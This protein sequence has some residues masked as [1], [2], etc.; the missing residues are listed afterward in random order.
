MSEPDA[1]LVGAVQLILDP[2]DAALKRFRGNEE[3]TQLVSAARV[4]TTNGLTQTNINHKGVH[5]IINVTVYP[6]AASVVPKIQG[7]DPLSSVFYDLLDGV[8]IVA[9]GTTVIKIYPGIAAL[10]NAAASD[11]LPRRWRVRMEHADADSITYSVGS[12]LVI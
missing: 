8:A 1:L 6:A 3:A 12:N 7:F 10:A 4:A 11:I 5:I 2:N 9:T